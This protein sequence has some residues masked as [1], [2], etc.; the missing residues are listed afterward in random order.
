MVRQR[1]P[2]QAEHLHRPQAARRSG[3]CS[4]RCSLGR[5][6][7]SEHEPQE[8][9]QL[10][11]DPASLTAR[12]P[13]LI[14]CALSGFGMDGP[15]RELPGYDLI[16][17]AR[18]GLM[19]VTGE[20]GGSPQRVS[21][22]LSDIATAF[23]GGLRRRFRAEP[24]AART[25]PAPCWWT[26]PSST[27]DLALMAPRI[28]CVPRGRA[29]AAALR[30]PPTRS[31]RSTRASPP[32]TAPWRSPSATTSSGGGSAPPWVSPSWPKDARYRTNEQR[33]EHRAHLVDR[34]EHVLTQQPM[35]HSLK[36]LTTAGVPCAPIQYLS[37]VR[38]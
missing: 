11:L 32:R 33:R 25:E 8:A 6:C 20:P 38:H 34:I 3:R 13:S 35:D 12:H 26:S 23:V 18:S 17:Q 1:E 7:S 29:R 36:I 22:A 4:T 2:Q 16:A 28:A 37:E 10:E 15:D 24:P 21:T 5:T 9:E 31:S 19:S 27:S 14:Y 30:G